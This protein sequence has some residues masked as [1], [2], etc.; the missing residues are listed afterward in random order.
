MLKFAP[1]LLDL[2]LRCLNRLCRVGLR[3]S[4]VAIF[5]ITPLL[6][7]PTNSNPTP[8]L[9][10]S[11]LVADLNRRLAETK[12]LLKEAESPGPLSPGETEQDRLARRVLLSQLVQS[13]EGH[14]FGLIEID[15]AKTRLNQLR[16][17]SKSWQGFPH[18]PPYS[19][20]L[21]DALRETIKAQEL[22][23]EAAS[24]TKQFIA[25]AH[26][27]TR[28]ELKRNETNIRRFT[29]ALE[30]ATDPAQKAKLKVALDLETL[31]SQFAS[32]ELGGLEAQSDVAEVEQTEA[33]QRRD[34]AQAQLAITTGQTV[35]T[36]ADLDRVTA[37]IEKEIDEFGVQFDAVNA[38]EPSRQ[39][40]LKQAEA[41]LEAAERTTPPPP[42]LPVLGEVVALRTDQVETERV[43]TELR[44]TTVQGYRQAQYV[45]QYRY[46]LSNAKEKP[47]SLAEAELISDSVERSTVGWSLK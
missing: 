11:N 9:E 15:S 14:L 19:L 17:E 4:A 39:A 37:Q 12:A 44:R 25:S 31:R 13:Y 23:T 22:K 42:D 40:E 34:F 7:Q 16:S 41:E 45:Y 20:L 26:D 18:G 43:Q 46:V 36:K 24:A 33:N 2:G 6:G 3:L 35:F 10:Q 28:K 5:S 38:T 21:A 30:F 29:E 1:L 27:E 47:G 32:A 8:N